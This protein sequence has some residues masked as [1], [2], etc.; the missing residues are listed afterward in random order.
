MG[1]WG[2]RWKERGD[3]GIEYLEIQQELGDY[4]GTNVEISCKGNSQK[5]I[6]VTLAK[7]PSKGEYRS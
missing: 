3:K 4:L 1:T 7:T 2:I 5:S 6:R